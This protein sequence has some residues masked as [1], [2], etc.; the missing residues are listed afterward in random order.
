MTFSIMPLSLTINML[1]SAK[2][3]FSITTL[4]INFFILSVMMLSV[5]MMNVAMLFVAML[6]VPMLMSVC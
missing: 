5:T 1:H 4:C 6:Y 3:K 2:M